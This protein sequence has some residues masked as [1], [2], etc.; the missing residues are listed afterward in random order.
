MK[1]NWRIW[2]GAAA[3]A[4]VIGAIA[5]YQAGTCATV[6]AAE[7]PAAPPALEKAHSLSDAFAWVADRVKP[8]VVSIIATKYI[9]MPR[10]HRYLNPFFFD[11][12]NQDED[13]PRRGGRG[14]EGARRF[15]QEGLGTGFIIDRSGYIVTAHHVIKGVDELKVF[16]AD[17][18]QFDA[19]VVG[20]DP[21]T[22]LAVI[23]INGKDLPTVP[24]GDSEAVRVGDWVIA[25]GSP[26]G[27]P[28]TVTA[29][30]VSAKGRQ[31]VMG[32]DGYEDFIQTDA[33]I[34]QG[35]SGGPLVN[36]RGE[37][38]GVN[39]AIYSASG[40]NAG[41]GFAVPSAMVKHV[42]PSLRAG[43][44]VQ[45][46]QLGV[47]IQ[48][49]NEDLAQ[50]F[51]LKQTTGVLVGEVTDGSAAQKAGI[52]RGDVILKY[53]GEAVEDVNDLRNRVA[54]TPPGGKAPVELIRK[55]KTMTITVTVG[56]ASATT[57]GATTE[58]AS[59]EKTSLAACRTY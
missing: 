18:R 30:I 43:K 44:P 37:V 5:F 6:V 52:Q 15:K 47:M 34:N 22:D 42:L 8:A 46:G 57:A 28:Q 26:Y 58:E 49:I 20:T 14:G 36:L 17:K 24:L 40:A 11:F 19:K 3:V 21:K 9:T 1:M 59:S 16:L 10:M 23:K 48:D 38:I 32:R 13:T 29:G 54:A 41:I 51:G 12:D 35:N 4:A 39:D 45:R 56:E 33:A 55:G 2:T 50:Q 31:G 7:Q 25:I 27:L 53:N